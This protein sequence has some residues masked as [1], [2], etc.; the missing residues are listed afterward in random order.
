MYKFVLA[1][2]G[3]FLFKGSFFGAIAGFFIGNAI[4]NF[5]QISE[6]LK[7]QGVGGG[8]T[9]GSRGFS[10]EDLFN[11]YQ[12]R[13]TTN[14][15]P[16]MLIALSAAVMK[17]DGKVLKSELTYVKG[18]FNQQFGPQF[19]TQHLQTLKQFLDSNSI[20]LNQICQDIRMRMQPEVRVQLLHYLFGIA[21][22]DGDVSTAEVGVIQQIASMM[23]V[24]T[25]DYE[26]V[27]NMFY[28]NVN[29]DYKILGV[30]V[31]ATDDEI[32]KAY[33]KMAIKFHPDKVAQM[34]EEYQKGAKEKFQKIQ[35][36]Y[37]AVKK[38]RGMK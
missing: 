9:G 32:K 23:G 21:K 27:K 3:Y 29:S 19:S 36:A 14:D 18:F 11:Y 2:G 25:S 33:R 15:V 6:R 1:V 24:A 12:Q 8:A 26:S 20:P 22:A 10:S 5:K 4:D 17:A 16:T 31:N 35:D 38:R 37:E 13:S 30:D 7:S 34:G 28:R